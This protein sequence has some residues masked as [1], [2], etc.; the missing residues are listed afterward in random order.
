MENGLKFLVNTEV[1]M[2]T[3]YLPSAPMPA[4]VSPGQKKYTASF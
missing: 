4:E 3:L 1:E 2:Y